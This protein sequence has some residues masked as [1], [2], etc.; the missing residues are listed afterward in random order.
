MHVAKYG[1]QLMQ[2]GVVPRAWDMINYLD[3]LTDLTLT[4]PRTQNAYI[5]R[6]LDPSVS[7]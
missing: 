7:S 5:Q 6:L 1:S 4:I 3:Y 2:F